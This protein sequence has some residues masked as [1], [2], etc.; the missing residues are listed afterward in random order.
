MGGGGQYGHIVK[1]SGI[2][3]KSSF[4]PYK[5]KKSHMH[6]YDIHKDLFINISLNTVNMTYLTVNNQLI[7]MLNCVW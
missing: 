2:L 1:L 5:F 7:N 4:L 6:S 3:G